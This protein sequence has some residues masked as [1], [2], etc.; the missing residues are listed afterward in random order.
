MGALVREG[1]GGG[2]GLAAASSLL[3]T[4]PLLCV[5]HG[6]GLALVVGLVAGWSRGVWPVNLAH[7]N[8]CG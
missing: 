6:P 7:L 2:A 3:P 1:G 4:F 5:V 8:G